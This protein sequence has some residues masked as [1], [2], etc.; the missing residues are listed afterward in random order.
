[1]T[2]D[3]E[4]NGQAFTALNGGPVFRFNEVISLQVHCQTQA[5]IDYYWEKLS[6]GGNETAQLKKLDIDQIKQAYNG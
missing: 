6:A 2:V 3:F 1:M 4:L 5:E